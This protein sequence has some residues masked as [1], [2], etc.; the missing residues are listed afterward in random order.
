[1]SDKRK[2][3]DHK[4]RLLKPGESQRKNLRYEYCYQIKG[5]KRI[6]VYDWDLKSLREQEKKIQKALDMGLDYEAGKVTVLELAERHVGLKSGSRSN[7]QANYNFVLNILRREKFGGY[8]IASIKPSDA[9]LWMKNLHNDGDGYSYSTL[10]T[11]RGVLKPAFQT[12]FEEDAVRRNP[13]DFKLSD[14][15][16]NDAV[17]RVALTQEEQERWMT[18]IRE[19]KHYSS[20]YDEYVVLLNTGMRISEF[21]GLTKKD[22]DFKEHRIRVDHQLIRSRSGKFYVEKTKT[23]S[24]C[25]YIPMTEEVEK[26][27]KN[28]LAKRPKAAAE[29]LIDGYTGFLVLDRKHNPKVANHYQKSMQRALEKYNQLHPENPLPHITPHVFRHTFCTNMANAG[30][31]IK[32]LQYLMGHSDV[33]TTLGIYAHASYENAAQ[34]MAVIVNGTDLFQTKKRKMPV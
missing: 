12:A 13:F 18:F 9:K 32:A 11:I 8:Q 14:V 23:Q 31:E 24:G 7:T 27:L 22:L 20:Y 1:M 33:G 34:Q 19:D 15:V 28:I 3:K 30:M 16:P 26:S 10:T 6:S 29:Q 4:G 25:R 5:G 17:A 21:C 2:R